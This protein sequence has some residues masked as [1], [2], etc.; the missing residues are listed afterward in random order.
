MR[1]EWDPR[2]Q[3]ANRLKHRIG[4]EEALTIFA[5]PLALIFDDLT[6][7]PA[8]REGTLPARLIPWLP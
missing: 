8:R 6:T 4:F 7:R 2:K 1:F 3:A 5:D